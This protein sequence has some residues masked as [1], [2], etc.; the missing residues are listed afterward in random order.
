MAFPTS[1]VL[2]DQHTIG[3]QIYQWNGVAW[4][5][6]IATTP[7][8]AEAASLYDPIGASVAMAIALGG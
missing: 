3:T 4:D 5:I 7:A 6:V 2:S 1:P 8:A